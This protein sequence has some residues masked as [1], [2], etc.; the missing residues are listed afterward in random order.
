MF[1]LR[2]RERE[3]ELYVSKRVRERERSPWLQPLFLEQEQEK[4]ASGVRLVPVMH[5]P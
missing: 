2:E 5:K 4:G 3:R 1:Q